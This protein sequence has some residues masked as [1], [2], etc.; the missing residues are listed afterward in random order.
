MW[1]RTLLNFESGSL[2]AIDDS[3]LGL[4]VTKAQLARVCGKSVQELRA[5]V[6]GMSLSTRSNAWPIDGTSWGG[7]SPVQPSD[8]A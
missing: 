3:L 2:S 1:S 8:L 4:P 7:H 6:H 5:L